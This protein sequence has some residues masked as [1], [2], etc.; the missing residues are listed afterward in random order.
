MTI[1]K[2]WGLIVLFFAFTL[3]GRRVGN[4]KWAMEWEW[5]TVTREMGIFKYFCVFGG[6]ANETIGDFVMFFM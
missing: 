4:G 6:D 5:E 1:L 3:G 2:G